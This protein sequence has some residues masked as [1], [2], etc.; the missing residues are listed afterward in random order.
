MRKFSIVAVLLSGGF[1]LG[2]CA[3]TDSP[4][5][6]QYNDADRV[7]DGDKIWNERPFNTQDQFRD[8]RYRR[9]DSYRYDNPDRFGRFEDQD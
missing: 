7:S 9:D 2:S 8:A 5:T 6:Y 1:L 4:Q 3:G